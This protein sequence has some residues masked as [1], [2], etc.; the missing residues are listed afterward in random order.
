MKKIL[1]IL[2]A[3]ALL[4]TA[5]AQQK[6]AE[7]AVPE[8][9][10]EIPAEE[11]TVPLV[12]TPAAPA[13]DTPVVPAETPLAETPAAPAEAPKAQTDEMDYEV[14]I[15]DKITYKDT[16]FTIDNMANSGNELYLNFN[17][18]ILKLKELNKPEILDNVEYKIASNENF[19]KAHTVTLNVKPLKLEKDQYLIMKEKSV[20]VNGTT[21]TLGEIRVEANGQVSTYVVVNER[22]YWVKLKETVDAGKLSV[23]LDRAFYQQWHYA[24]LTLVPK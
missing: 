9:P 4:L 20:S 8:V 10:A 19:V 7:T 16:V 15:G 17:A 22:A 24:I 21:V 23:T 5:C 6:A 3:L 18:F 14:A 11:P 2:L 13:E 1:V 12:E